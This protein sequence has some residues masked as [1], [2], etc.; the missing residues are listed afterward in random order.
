M[1]FFLKSNYRS[2][3]QVQVKRPLKN[4]T[5][6]QRK[7]PRLTDLKDAV[8]PQPD[9][10]SGETP[11]LSE[12]FEQASSENVAA[13]RK[14]ELRLPS[15]TL[16][17]KSPHPHPTTSQYPSPLEPYS[18]PL[19]VSAQTGHWS[20]SDKPMDGPHERG[21]IEQSTSSQHRPS[22][23]L[24]LNGAQADPPGP[25]QQQ[26]SLLLSLQ[27]QPEEANVTATVQPGAGTDNPYDVPL[28]PQHH[29]EIQLDSL[30]NKD[31]CQ[32][33]VLG[34]GGQPVVP[35]GRRLFSTY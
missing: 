3:D 35:Q 22:A 1:I 9:V 4:K 2:K 20:Q 34:S 10:P 6:H 33:T 23:E 16:P 8:N 11:L 30:Q 13:G 28:P 24:N 12:V 32:E 21:R 25:S 26:V 7:R 27:Q 5:K 15:H 18:Q 14:I 19:A 29:R 17:P 31:L